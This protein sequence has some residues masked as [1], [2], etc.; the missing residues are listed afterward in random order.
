MKTDSTREA[1]DGEKPKTMDKKFVQFNEISK[2]K[3]A[4]WWN[5][6]ESEN[7]A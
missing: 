7:G 2:N 1:T 3:P 5:Q 4:A 6:Q